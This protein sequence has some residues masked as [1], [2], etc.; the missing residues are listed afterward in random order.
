M[1]RWGGQLPPLSFGRTF[2]DYRDQMLDTLPLKMLPPFSRM[3]Q[4][5]REELFL[6][7]PNKELLIPLFING[8][9]LCGVFLVFDRDQGREFAIFPSAVF[10]G[11]VNAVV[12]VN[13]VD[14]AH[15][16]IRGRS[17]PHRRTVTALANI[18]LH[19]ETAERDPFIALPVMPNACKCAEG[20]GTLGEVC[21]CRS[22][23]KR[24]CDRTDLIV[25]NGLSRQNE[26]RGHKYGHNATE[27]YSLGTP[28]AFQIHGAPHIIAPG[29]E[30]TLRKCSLASPANR[31]A[32]Y[33]WM[34]TRK[35]G[36]LPAKE[37]DYYRYGAY[38]KSMP[39]PRGISGPQK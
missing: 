6:P 26:Q 7:Y 16:E 35:L 27:A 15:R 1:M 17:R 23:C 10:A 31:S 13:I 14:T 39:S 28:V 9:H 22:V 8:V 11:E 3:N 21:L 4:G 24:V 38:N 5:G 19:L 34:N 25:V 32:Q 12:R 18:A 29:M 2:F 33:V 30:I 36:K 20:S 37:C